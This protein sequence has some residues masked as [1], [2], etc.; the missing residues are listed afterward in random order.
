[1]TRTG[2]REIRSVSGRVGMYAMVVW[3]SA[4]LIVIALVLMEAASVPYELVLVVDVIL[5]I[6]GLSAYH[7]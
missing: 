1:V 3:L 5:S 7:L 6:S 2:D 4:L